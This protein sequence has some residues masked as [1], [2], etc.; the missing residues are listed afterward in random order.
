[1]TLVYKTEIGL[2]HYTTEASEKNFERTGA[3]KSTDTFKPKDIKIALTETGFL[4]K[5]NKSNSPMKK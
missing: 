3:F 1:M 2:K 5:Y 4:K